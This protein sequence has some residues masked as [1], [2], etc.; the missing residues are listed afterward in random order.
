MKFVVD[1]SLE[2]AAEVDA[3]NIED[4]EKLIE[5]ELQNLIANNKDLLNKIGAASVQGT[6]RK[7][8]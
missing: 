4:A 2:G 7:L 3:E 1:W 6:G 5:Q 8:N